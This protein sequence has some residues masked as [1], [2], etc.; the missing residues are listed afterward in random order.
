MLVNTTQFANYNTN[1]FKNKK[2]I[3]KKDCEK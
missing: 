1:N 2:K 3:L